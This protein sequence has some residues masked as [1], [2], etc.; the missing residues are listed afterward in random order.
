MATLLKDISELAPSEEMPCRCNACGKTFFI[1]KSE[2]ARVIKGTRKRNACSVECS[3]LLLSKTIL[4]RRVSRVCKCCK[5]SF[6]PA[7][8]SQ[9]FCSNQCLGKSRK[10]ERPCLCCGKTIRN[11]KFC[12]SKCS[13]EYRKQKGVREWLNGEKE[14]HYNGKTFLV[15]RNIREYLKER[16]GEKCSKCGWSERHPV[17]GSVPLEINHID[18]D[19]SN[20]SIENLEVLCP[21]C[22]S[23]TPN[24]R[25]LNKGSRRNRSEKESE[26]MEGIEPPMIPDY[27]SGAVANCAT[28]A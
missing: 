18:G 19:A 28:S 20:S 25:S 24:F 9:V 8:S 15:R 7:K 6:F 27:K 13:G 3:R 10:K 2:A 11:K 4:D 22:H 12:C 16:A 21:N 1:S 5:K 23:L 17:T 14:G 26:P